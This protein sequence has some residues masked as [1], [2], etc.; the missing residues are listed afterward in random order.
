MAD[1]LASHDE[2]SIVKFV[3]KEI[4]SNSQF[5]Q[6]L[7]ILI[8]R[9]RSAENEP[10][11]RRLMA[12]VGSGDGA[13]LEVT[14]LDYHMRQNTRL[15]HTDMFMLTQSN[16]ATLVVRRGCPVTFSVQFDRDYDGSVD[17]VV[18]ILSTGLEPKEEDHSLV[19]L[20]VP[21]V[22]G[23]FY[24]T[25]NSPWSI[26]LVLTE[27]KSL[28]VKVMLPPGAA[29]GLWNLSVETKLRASDNKE[30]SAVFNVKDTFYILFN[31]WCYEDY[32]Y[33]EDEEMLKEYL[34]NDSGKL[35]QGNWDYPTG[36]RWYFGQF[37]DVVLPAC[38]Y[39]FELGEMT[40]KDRS[41][42]VSMAR[43]IAALVDAKDENGL[44]VGSWTGNYWDGVAPTAWSSSISILE[45][46]MN[47]G[48]A[49]VMY[50]QCWV[51]SG[52]V[53]TLCR[54]LGI[55]CRSITNFSSAHDTD[56]NLIIERY[57]D[58]H[59][60]PIAGKTEDSIWNFHLWNELWMA[61]PDLP[62]GYGGWQ[63]IDATPQTISDGLFRVGPCPVSAIFNGHIDVDY[64]TRFV[65]AEVNGDFVSWK[66]DAV[67]RQ[68]RRQ[69]DD[70]E[71][72]GMLVYTKKIGVMTEQDVEDAE[73][74]TP[75]YK[76]AKVILPKKLEGM[77][78]AAKLSDVDM[79]ME[80][81][82]SVQ[83]GQP[84]N[85][86]L[87]LTNKSKEKRHV[88]ATLAA[89][90]M[91]YSGGTYKGIKRQ[92]FQVDLE[93][94]AAAS[95]SLTINPKEYQNKLAPYNIVKLLGSGYVEGSSADG[96][97]KQQRITVGNPGMTIDVSGPL[98]VAKN[99]EYTL[100][101][102][103]P[104]NTPLTDCSLTVDIPGVTQTSST[105]RVADIPALGKFEYTGHVIPRRPGNKSILAVFN[106]RQVKDIRGTK[107]VRIS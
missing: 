97:T 30:D 66:R 8:E 48:G 77:S 21:Q 57:F 52:L 15:H 49:P 61:R 65:Y 12:H 18:L 35:Y 25:D 104:L 58:E 74:V 81:V 73:D 89:A 6:Y 59:G 1:D 32:V 23:S 38:N 24:A 13:P 71:T 26:C 56:G 29:V 67:T 87:T 16:D 79:A 69:L 72:A 62:P 107:D 4:D 27:K 40:A 5:L 94:G 99:L 46:Y 60:N 83:L 43:A 7:E 82:S 33:L 17:Q 39:L 44:L 98:T 55:P 51:Y 100:R 2:E 53:T 19:K 102:T 95:R 31:P 36:K 22:K 42:P 75:L 64:D 91:Y 70:T 37:C 92:V 103:N 14:Q 9:L 80:N 76:G 20:E 93:A 105:Q 45:Q 10:P 90:S 68:F 54:A 78:G 63:V 88:T 41:S 11:A 84:I 101:F 96:W 85:I 50:G 34:L 106:S 28:T 3:K 86:R 47:T